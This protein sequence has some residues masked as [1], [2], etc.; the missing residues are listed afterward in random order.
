MK[1]EDGGK[2]WGQDQQ[3]AGAGG[4]GAGSRGEAQS[5][6]WGGA[7]SAL[8]AMDRDTASEGGGS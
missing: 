2:G 1:Q 7:A 6:P 3:A 5:G 8:V 4:E